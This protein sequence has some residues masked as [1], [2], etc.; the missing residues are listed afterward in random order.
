MR[1]DLDMIGDLCTE[2]GLRIVGRSSQEVAVELED[3]V[4]LIFVNADREED[5]LIGFE[6]G[7]W[8]YHGDLMCSDR[9]GALIELGYLDLLTG[10]ANGAVLV[11]EQWVG[12]E[13]RERSLVHRDYLDEF[14]HMEEGEEYRIRRVSSPRGPVEK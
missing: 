11:C 7:E 1:Y 5:S 13:L 12:S 6:G 2:L 10:L 9:H 3:G 4:V 8:H 14:R